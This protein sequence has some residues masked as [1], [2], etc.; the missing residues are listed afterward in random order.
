MTNSPANNCEQLAGV[1]CQLATQILGASCPTTPAAC[2]TCQRSSVSRAL[3]SVTV[4][5]AIA[6]ARRTQPERVAPLLVAHA[7]LLMPPTIAT[8]VQTFAEA[9]AQ[10]IAAGRPVRDEAEVLR[11]YDDICGPCDRR[12]ATAEP[13]V[14]WCQ[15]CGCRLG[16]GGQVLNKILL[17]TEHCPL[18]KW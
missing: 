11:I 18:G 12:E 4:S 17:A 13:D 9:T 7:K 2:A 16:R 3:N 1:T 14:S 8:R 15:Q 6:E 10:W 5:L